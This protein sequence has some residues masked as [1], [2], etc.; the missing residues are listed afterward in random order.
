MTRLFSF[1][2]CLSFFFVAS[3]NAHHSDASYDQTKTITLQGVVTSYVWRNPHVTIYVEAPDNNGDIAEWALEIGSTMIMTR[4]GWSRD[5]LK[6]GDLVQATAYP[7][8]NPQDHDVMLI[9]IQTADG[10]VYIQDESD[11]IGTSTTDSFE[12]VWKGRG[13]TIIEFA[14]AMSEASLTDKATLAKSSYDYRLHSPIAQCVPPP[15]PTW[16]RGMIIYL[17]EFD[18]LD[19]RVIIKNE[20]FDNQRIIYMDGRAHPEAGE[21][22]NQGHSIGFWEDDVLVVDTVLF[23]DHRSSF[24]RGVPNGSQK[25][26]I[27]RFYLNKEG[28]RMNV[29]ILV[30][31]PEFLA[32]PWSGTMQL[33]YTPEYSI[34][35]YNCDPEF[36]GFE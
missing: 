5:L 18:I 21:R 8:R 35:E 20:F 14:K 29:D 3:S 25:H 31:D 10:S 32:E 28:T 22:T 12:G 17:T 16:L 4:S 19:D 6:E 13:S 11:Y 26:T 24:D 9:N 36:A 27:E 2:I 7:N 30:E 1:F 15:T 34:Q 23:E 33:D